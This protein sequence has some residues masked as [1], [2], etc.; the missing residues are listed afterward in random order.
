MRKSFFI[1]ILLLSINVSAQMQANRFEDEASTQQTDQY[2]AES[3]EKEPEV[4][5]GPGG[6]GEDPVPIDDYIPL[7]VI[8]AAVLIAYKTYHR[9][10]LSR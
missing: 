7:L 4:A 2:E 10:S 8:I 9:K 3:S 1:F 6:P 5:Y